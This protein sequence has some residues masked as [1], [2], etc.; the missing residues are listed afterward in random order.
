VGFTTRVRR[1]VKELLGLP[2]WEVT[3]KI[4]EFEDQLYEAFIR[5]GD[6]VFDVGA[7]GGDLS[8][9]FACLAGASGKVYAF[10]PVWPMYEQLCRKVELLKPPAASV[11][12]VPNGFAEEDRLATLQVPSNK[13]SRASLAP[14]D[15]WKHA[16]NASQVQSFECSLLT[17][18][19]FTFR[20]A[21][22][23][24]DFIKVDVEGAELFVLR[25]ASAF[26]ASGHRPAMLIELFAPWEKAFGYRPWEVLSLLAD[27]GY[28]CLFVCPC[29]LVEH[30]PTRERPFPTE[31]INGYNVLAVMPSAHAD[32]IMRLSPLY[33]GAG[34]KILPMTP[35]PVLNTIE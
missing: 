5:E 10:E 4:T 34:G 7:N 11:I 33:A 32:R 29:G 13:F 27:L 30:T 1:A 25:G 16:Q 23:V 2:Q 12:P 14:A 9:L 3:P 8:A 24:P 6:H 18:D 17:L 22:R 21:A 15:A 26:F 19:T 20:T 31:Y 28:E 35:P